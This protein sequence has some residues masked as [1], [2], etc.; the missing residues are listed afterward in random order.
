MEAEEERP[1]TFVERVLTL[2]EERFLWLVHVGMNLS[3]ELT[4]SKNSPTGR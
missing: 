1:R 4:Q 2:L 3:R